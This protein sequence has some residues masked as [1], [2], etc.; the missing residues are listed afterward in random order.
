MLRSDAF[1]PFVGLPYVTTE[2]ME[3]LWGEHADL[4]D[5]QAVSEMICIWDI[6]M[7]FVW[8]AGFII[9]DGEMNNV[10]E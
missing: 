10:H 8:C 2:D 4:N 1:E 9:A 3:D 7:P 6:R 5:I